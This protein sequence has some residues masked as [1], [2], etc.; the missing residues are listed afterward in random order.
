MGRPNAQTSG[1]PHCA[2]VGVGPHSC[3]LAKERAKR[4]AS[5]PPGSTPSWQWLL[6]LQLAEEY[7]PQTQLNGKG[8]GLLGFVSLGWV[9]L[10]LPAMLTHTEECRGNGCDEIKG[11]E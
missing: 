10:G 5:G 1:P 6:L 8:Q 7:R 11:R 3:P 4:K 2:E 9:T